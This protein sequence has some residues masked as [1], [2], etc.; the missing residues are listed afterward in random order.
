MLSPLLALFA[1]Q[2]S[3]PGIVEQAILAQ[4]FLCTHACSPTRGRS[5]YMIMEDL[6]TYAI[7]PSW[8]SGIGASLLIF[9]YMATCSSEYASVPREH[10]LDIV[11]C[12]VSDNSPRLKPGASQFDRTPSGDRP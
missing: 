8:V 4:A 1:C 9:Y 12:I 6:P 11:R 2:R 10:P 5:Q 7:S 3:C